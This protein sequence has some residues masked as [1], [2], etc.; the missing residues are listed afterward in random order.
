MTERFIIDN[1]C[2]RDI[3]GFIEPIP[4][5]SMHQA[6]KVR[7]LLNRNWEQFNEQKC[8]IKRLRLQNK[9]LHKINGE[10]CRRI[11]DVE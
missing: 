11:G 5:I 4:I 6:I 3:L 7:D 8:L 9:E 1:D 10:L 2:I